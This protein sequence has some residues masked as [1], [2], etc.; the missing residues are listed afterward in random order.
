MNAVSAA[1]QPAPFESAQSG[2][3]VTVVLE[4]E[5]GE[6]ELKQVMQMLFR[7]TSRGVTRVVMDLSEVSHFDYRGVRPLTARAELLRDAGG[8]LK[9]CGLS[10]YLAAIFR[11]AGAHDAFEYLPNAPQARGA[12]EPSTLAVG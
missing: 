5:I 9:L 8:D 6:R 12:F 4:G 10:P 1:V 3:V 2:R 11:S 7:I